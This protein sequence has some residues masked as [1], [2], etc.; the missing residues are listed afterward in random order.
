[1]EILRPKSTLPVDGVQAGIAKTEYSRPVGPPDY[2]E[3]V[4]GKAAPCM[5]EG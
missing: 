2:A 5:N 3:L 4:M 1:L